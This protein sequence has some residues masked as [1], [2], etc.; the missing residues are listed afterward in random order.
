LKKEVKQ[1]KKY[2]IN[3]HRL[4]FDKREQMPLEYLSHSGKPRFFD[5]LE[6][7]KS[8]L[9]CMDKTEHNYQKLHHSKKNLVQKLIDNE[10]VVNAVVC[11]LFQWFGTNVGRCDI[12]EI[13]EKINSINHLGGKC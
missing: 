10:E 5:N 6:M 4:E 9:L 11:T 2:C 7:L 12:G 3:S 1:L 13:I 8:L